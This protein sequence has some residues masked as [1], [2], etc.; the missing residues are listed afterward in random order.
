MTAK[1]R[2]KNDLD[3]NK[4]RIVIISQLNLI[5]EKGANRRRENLPTINKIVLLISKKDGQALGYD[6]IF[7]LKT[8]RPIADQ[9]FYL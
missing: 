5:I 9:N 7:I 8:D 4:N 3:L 6:L 2:L 1:E